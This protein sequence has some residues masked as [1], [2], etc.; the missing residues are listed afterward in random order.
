[1]QKIPHLILAFFLLAADQLSKWFMSE[2]IIRPA[3][4]GAGAPVGFAEWLSMPVG[5]LPFASIEVLPFFNIVMVWNQGVSFGM[6]NGSSAYGPLILSGLSLVIAGIFLVWLFRSRS[7]LQCFAIVFVIAGALGN[8]V[9]RVR[10]GAVIDF[11]DFHIAGL[12]WPAFNVADSCVFIGVFLLIVQS[13]FFET[14]KK[15]AK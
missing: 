8:V 4:D 15:D 9:D 1:M 14:G 10:F 5:R 2:Q 13:F 3:L 6:F 12:H 7:K 11:L